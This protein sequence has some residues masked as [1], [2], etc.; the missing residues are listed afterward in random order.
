MNRF[1]DSLCLLNFFFLSFVVAGV[2]VCVRDGVSLCVSVSLYS[3]YFTFLVA[4]AVVCVRHPV[5]LIGA[6]NKVE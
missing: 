2:C 1:S 4:R 3:I 5:I 6:V